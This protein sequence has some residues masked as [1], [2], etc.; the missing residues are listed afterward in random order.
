MP[1][2]STYVSTNSRTFLDSALDTE[3][4]PLLSHLHHS[5]FLSEISPIAARFH[6]FLSCEPIPSFHGSFLP[7][8][9]GD[10]ATSV[11]TKNVGGQSYAVLP[12]NLTWC[13]GIGGCRGLLYTGRESIKNERNVKYDRISKSCKVKGGAARCGW[14]EIWVSW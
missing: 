13:I 5:V 2:N 9:E 8:A 11:Q 7:L 4:V 1:P 10:L 6:E 14:V 3:N 12:I